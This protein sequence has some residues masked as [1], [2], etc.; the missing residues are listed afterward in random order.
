MNRLLLIVLC[1]A[2]AAFA[3]DDDWKQVKSKADAVTKAINT[4]SIWTSASN[5]AGQLAAFDSWAAGNVKTFR[6]DQS[7]KAAFETFK[8]NIKQALLNNLDQ[9]KTW[10]S[11]PNTFFDLTFEEFAAQRLMK[12]Q[13]PSV[14]PATTSTVQS[15]RSLRAT[16]VN[17]V[18]AGKVPPIRD[19]GGCGSCW[20]FAATSAI[21]SRY[22]IS[23]LG[24]LPGDLVLSEQ[25]IV[26]C[27]NAANGYGSGGC[28]GGWPPDAISYAAQFNQTSNSIYPYAG[29]TGTCSI[30]IAA[31]APGSVL[32]LTGSP[33]YFN[34][35]SE[36]AL[37][38]AVDVAPTVITFLVSNSFYSYGGGVYAGTDCATSGINHAMV[39]VGYSTSS[40]PP[41]W[42]VRNSWGTGWGEGGY[43]RIAMTG[44]GNG[45][46]NILQYN[47]VQPPATFAK[48]F[49]APFSP[50]P[51][52]QFPPSPPPPPPPP[53][54]HPSP[55]P[56][57]PTPH[58]PPPPPPPPPSPPPPQSPI[59][60]GYCLDGSLPK[61][62][63][64][65]QGYPINITCPVGIVI[66]SVPSAS[67]GH[68]S[69]T[70]N[71]ANAT[72]I[73]AP[74]LIGLNSISFVV[75][76]NATGGPSW[77]P[78]PCQGYPRPSYFKLQVS[79]CCGAFTGR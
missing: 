43:V 32:K 18:A 69:S 1:I 56:P 50:P 70:C 12:T 25:Q 73:I 35:L 68:V 13:A 75:R 16:D 34:T 58:S 71:L 76:S 2:R 79:F 62:A 64:A 33:I 27:V 11:A 26:S 47:P 5:T 39:V 4:L 6:N 55:S 67:Y 9:K 72:A 10:W 28:D 41:Y 22:L 77:L 45:I 38:A 42:L 51:L 63:A 24:S 48:T 74:N 40:S 7:K 57:P 49:G 23:V 65:G 37:K 53:P 61:K 14:S 3:S 44:D 17:W 52:S 19:Q 46:C 54:P 8:V 29:I 15:R 21:A 20:A 31:Q 78:L 30:P 59:P 66:I 60:P 36:A